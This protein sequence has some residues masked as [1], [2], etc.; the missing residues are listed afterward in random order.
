MI[1]CKKSAGERTAATETPLSTSTGHWELA[2]RSAKSVNHPE[3]W[4]WSYNAISV[5]SPSVVFVA[6]D[7]PRPDNVEKRIGVIVRTTDG[8][9]T[10][11]EVQLDIK[12]VDLTFLSSINFASTTVGWAAG[13]DESGHTVVF[14][15]SDGGQTWSAQ[16]TPFVQSPTSVK[17]GGNEKGWIAGVKAPPDDPDSE[18]GPS[19]ILFSSDGGSTWSA[20]CHLP[21]SISDL[22][23]P[24]ESEGWAAG[25]PA[26]IYH[27]SDGGRTWGPQQT[28]LEGGSPGTPAASK[29]RVL[30]V[31]FVDRQHGWAGAANSATSP[32]EKR[33]AVFGST[34]GGSTW[35]TLWVMQGETFRELHF[36]NQQEGWAATDNGQYIY[37]TTDGGHRWLSEEIKSLEQH[38]NF[39]RIGAADSTHVWAVGGGAII[40]RVEE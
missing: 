35:A 19:D 31:D 7:Y 36:L 5:V 26:S 32:D 16:R 18:E 13:S 34:N 22:S 40:K 20:Q 10:W 1:G 12:G 14:K 23:F 24:F 15:T 27:T 17:F 29:Y 33:S 39:Y 8:G 3:P 11:T 2:Y 25:M 9:A 4:L 30:R 21:V 37:H 6:A 28:G 38:L